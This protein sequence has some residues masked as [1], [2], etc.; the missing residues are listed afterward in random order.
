MRRRIATLAAMS[1]LTLALGVTPAL[2]GSPAVHLSW[3]AAPNNPPIHCGANTY[4]MVSGTIDE[5]IHAGASASGNLNFAAT[6]RATNVTAEDQNGNLYP[7]VGAEHFGGTINITTG[8][9]QDITVFKLRVV[10]TGDSLNVILRT[11]PN[12]EFKVFGPGTCPVV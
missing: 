10:G 1:V 4:T 9:S 8:R 5:V 7:V 12:G 2:A 3:D 6:V 11:M